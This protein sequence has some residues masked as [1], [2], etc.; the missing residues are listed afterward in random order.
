VLPAEQALA[1]ALAQDDSLAFVSGAFQL[2]VALITEEEEIDEASHSG[3]G[4]G[5][6]EHDHDL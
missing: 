5:R 6:H 2:A 4:V 3:A 1:L